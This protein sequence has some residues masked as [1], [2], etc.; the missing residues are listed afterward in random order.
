MAGNITLDY[1]GV[2]RELRN[3]TKEFKNRLQRNLELSVLEEI[4]MASRRN[5]RNRTGRLWR[6]QRRIPGRGARIGS[7]HA[8]Y[9]QYLDKFTRGSGRFIRHLLDAPDVR[10]RILERAVQRTERE[11]GF[12]GI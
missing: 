4:R 10:D 3:N 2:F 1:S 9:W 5:Y 8:P 12:A 11:M 7:R 6:S